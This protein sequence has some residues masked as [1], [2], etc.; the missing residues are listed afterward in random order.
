MTQKPQAAEF[1]GV[2]MGMDAEGKLFIRLTERR[3]GTTG[4]LLTLAEARRLHCWLGAALPHEPS[5]PKPKPMR[6]VGPED[7]DR[8][9]PAAPADAPG[10]D[11]DSNKGKLP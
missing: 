8:A 9:G 4:A 2:Q 6:P 1:G 11:S 3:A 5:S 10:S 7:E